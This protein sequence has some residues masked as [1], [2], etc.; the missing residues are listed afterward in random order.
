MAQVYNEK[1]QAPMGY[2][3]PPPQAGGVYTQQ[4]PGGYAQPPPTGI[5]AQPPPGGVYTQPPPTAPM[6]MGGGNRNVRGLPYDAN[7]QREWSHGLLGCFGDIKTC[8]LAS[9]CPCLAHARNRRRL[10]HL[11]TTGQPD[12]DRDGL[13][14]PDGWLYTCLEVACDMGWILQIGTRAAIRQ[15]YNIRGSDGG[16]CMAAFCCQA[17]DLVQGSRELE[18]EEDSFGPQYA[19]A[20]PGAHGAHGAPQGPQGQ[21]VQKV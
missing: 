20:P 21:V 17:C 10:H 7:G 1:P 12:P 5:Y 3:Q 16:D 4:P 11:E 19:P 8:C 15:R 6:N 2:A 14:G 13:C 9:W 18:L